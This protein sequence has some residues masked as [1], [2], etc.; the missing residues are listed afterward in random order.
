MKTCN[1]LVVSDTEF[2][3]QACSNVFSS[4]LQRVNTFLFGSLSSLYFEETKDILYC[5]SE[6]SPRRQAIAA[7]LGYV[8]LCEL[9][10]SREPAVL[11]PEM[12]RF[13]IG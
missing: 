12:C 9:C 2:G 5:D 8:S 13:S 11:I 6:T 7:V 3:F 1:F 10:P 4:A